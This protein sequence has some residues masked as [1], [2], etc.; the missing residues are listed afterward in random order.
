MILGYIIPFF[1]AMGSLKEENRTMMK[2]AAVTT[3]IGLYLAKS[4]WLEIPQMIPLS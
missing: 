4:T 2:F 3:L 1:I